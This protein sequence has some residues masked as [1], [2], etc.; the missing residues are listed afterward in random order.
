MARNSLI[1]LSLIISIKAHSFTLNNSA[2]AA[3]GSDDVTVNV[4]NLSCS[5][6]S[7]SEV[8]SL[9]P[10]AIDMWNAAPSS[11]LNL[12]SG[13]LQSTSD[14]FRTAALCNSG[15]GNSNSCDINSTLSVGSGILI[16]CNNSSSNFASTSILGVSI[17]NNIDGTTI[18]GALVLLNDN[19]GAFNSLSRADKVAVIAHEIGH[20]IGLGHSPVNDSLMFFST[21]PVR[22]NL[23]WDDIDGVT[24]LYP[25][26]QPIGCGS[27]NLGE[28]KKGPSNGFFLL[29]LFG[30]LFLFL[31]RKRKKVL[32]RK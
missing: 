15:S 20:A 17:P 3:F 28:K 30:V 7:P 29:S 24:Y 18:N 25:A 19:S 10:E 16:A 27:I 22:E 31:L 13:E 11:R 26:E 6:V 23:G 4:A 5:N 2:Q 14:T 32:I 1:L 9:L 12:Q 21:V 8:L